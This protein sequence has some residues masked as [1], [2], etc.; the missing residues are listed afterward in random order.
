[1]KLILKNEYSFWKSDIS[2]DKISMFVWKN[3]ELSKSLNETPVKKMDFL[4][5]Q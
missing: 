4:C 5:S 2:Q 3:L 1:M